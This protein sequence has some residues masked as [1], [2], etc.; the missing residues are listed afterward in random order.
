MADT[1]R[2]LI[3]P[4]KY[5]EYSD[6]LISIGTAYNS[7]FYRQFMD[8]KIPT[9]P[10]GVF[11]YG[12]SLFKIAINHIALF[13]DLEKTWEDFIIIFL[14]SF[15]S[16]SRYIRINLQLPEDLSRLNEISNLRYF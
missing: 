16:R 4:N 13:L 9:S 2:K 15:I 1:E 5:N 14:M 3:W 6:I 7:R 8:N 11:A 10:S 12:K